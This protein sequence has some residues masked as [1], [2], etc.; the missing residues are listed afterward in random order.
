MQFSSVLM[1]GMAD[2]II[3]RILDKH[4]ES[5]GYQ[6][7]ERIT[8]ESKNLFA[9]QEGTL[10]PLLYKM[11]RDGLVTSHR[12]TALTGKERR[13]YKLTDEGKVY[14]SS[15]SKEFKGFLQGVQSVFDWSTV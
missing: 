10:Y 6:L 13:Y 4:G 15:R 8:E 14:L 5:Y 7:I 9:F 3:L 2:V 1:K 12:K 11:E